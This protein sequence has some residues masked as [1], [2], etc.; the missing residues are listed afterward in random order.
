MR[1][2]FLHPAL[3]FTDSTARL[4]ASVE[5][6]R[7]AGHEVCVISRKG[8]CTSALLRTGASCFEGELPEH[9]LLGFFAAG[10][11]RDQLS[12]LAPDL[13]HVT[14]ARLAPL[15]AKVAEALARPYLLEIGQAIDAPLKLSKT[16][17]RGV[18]L[19]CET[20]VE[21]AV[22]KGA[23]TRDLL[24]VIPPGPSLEVDWQPRPRIEGRRP[25]VLCLGTLDEA[26]D[27]E[28]LVRAAK[29]QAESGQNLDYLV[30]GEGPE[31]FRLRRL[32]RELDLG[33]SFAIASPGLTSPTVA[34][35]QA[36]YHVACLRSGSLGWSTVQALG[37][38]IPSIL[39]AISGTF[40]WIEDRVDGLLV[41]PGD[42]QK[43]AESLAVLLGNEAA[44]KTM[45]VKAREAMLAKELDLQF[46]T[47]LGD[48]QDAAM[49]VQRA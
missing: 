10:R 43:L 40:P 12:S 47:A 18:I 36:D 31:E 5:A 35:E 6:S 16:F 24:T 42:P 30:L 34:M 39:S 7:D 33:D 26:H 3:D 29:L 4:I 15:A 23:L 49:G 11:T 44:A 17:L 9:G 14:D 22:N 21:R 41:K 13:L 8:S 48:L 37:L 38:G 45:G 25:V 28:T 1:I 19:P 27:I 46:A 20:F 2:T 32:V